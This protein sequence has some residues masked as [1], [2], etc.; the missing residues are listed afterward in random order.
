M[1]GFR[2]RPKDA[3]ATY[4]TIPFSEIP[5]GVNA[6]KFC[7]G[8]HAYR[9]CPRVLRISYYDD[10]TDPERI[11]AVEFDPKI[12]AQLWADVVWV[13]EEPLSKE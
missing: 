10:T 13:E 12:N 8:M 3:T 11:A 4:R 1:F 9:P 6:C 7:S 2:R 5:K